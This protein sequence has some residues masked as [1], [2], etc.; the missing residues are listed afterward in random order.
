M[1]DGGAC[2]HRD[3][4]FIVEKRSLSVNSFTVAGAK[5]IHLTPF[6]VSDLLEHRTAHANVL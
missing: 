2:T 5:V 3:C 6:C 1:D 4:I